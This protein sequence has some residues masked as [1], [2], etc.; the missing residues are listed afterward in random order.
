MRHK[1]LLFSFTIL[2]LAGCIKKNVKKPTD[3]NMDYKELSKKP[4][5]LYLTYHSLP[6]LFPNATIELRNPSERLNNLGYTLR[7]NKDASVIFMIGQSISFNE[8]EVDSLVSFVEEGNQVLLS[9][10]NF[11]ESLLNKLQLKMN[12]HELINDSLQKIYL[13]RP[14]GTQESYT[15]T[16]KRFRFQQEFESTDTTHTFFATAG[17]NQFQKPNLIVFT[18][19]KG[20]LLLHADPLAFSNYFLLQGNNKNYLPGLFSNI[21]DPISNVYF[22]SFNYREISNSDF[23]ILWRNRGTRLALILIFVALGIYLLFET[24]RRQRIIPILKPIQNDSVAFTETIGRLYYNNKNH[25]NLAEKMAQHFLEF[26]RSRY[27]LNTNT[28]DAAFTKLLA[29]KS[30]I[31][32]ATTDALIYNIKMVYDGMPVDEAFLFALYTQIQVFYNGK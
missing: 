30:G 28:L 32:I 21:Q 14:D 1:L 13:N 26:V 17:T 4:Y 16:Y 23:G 22:I 3:W 7:K 29:A 20:R 12:Q 10:Y 2:L 11:D 27:Y 24:K 8:A 25:A 9:A 5:S 15:S 6:L 31:D 19:G 18:A